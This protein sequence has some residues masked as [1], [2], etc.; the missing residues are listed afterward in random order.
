MLE[1]Q[2]PKSWGFDAPFRVT[3]NFS[4]IHL[5][6]KTKWCATNGSYMKRMSAILGVLAASPS[7]HNTWQHLRQHTKIE[8]KTAIKAQIPD[9][10]APAIFTFTVVV[11][12]VDLS[13]TLELKSGTHLLLR[14][15]SSKRLSWQLTINIQSI[16]VPA[17]FSHTASR[18]VSRLITSSLHG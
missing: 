4:S 6:T 15:D 17:I 5:C 9:F 12:N 13:M 14:L 1:L 18:R 8:T 11:M 16:Q 3:H 7:R 2:I 10:V